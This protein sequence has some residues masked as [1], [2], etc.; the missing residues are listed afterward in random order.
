MKK[1][2]V[3]EGG[4]MRGMFTAGVL[5]V[6][7]EKGI[8]FNGAVGVS[9]GAVFGCNLKSHQIGRAIRYNKRFAGDPRYASFRSLLRTGDLYN[10]EFCYHT[11]PDELDPFDRE[12]YRADP[13]DFYVTVSDAVTG[14]PVY[15]LCNTGDDSDLK[16][17]QAS[18][19]M[20]VFAKPVAIDGG[21]YLDGGITDSIPVRFLMGKGYDRVVVVLTQ[22]AD[23]RKN[24]SGMHR[25][26]R[27]LLPKYPMVAECM[28]VRHEKYNETLDYI[29][30]MENEGKIMAI[31]PAA[32]LGIGK[33]ER[34]PEELERVYQ[35][36]RAECEKNL[37]KLKEYLNK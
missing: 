6:L 12:A 1:G 27:A 2:I 29:A 22:P 7:M 13:M 37:E 15:K 25:A 34:K 26:I 9:A 11:L 5:D 10:A 28:K 8:S 18:A 17:M 36:G 33:M 4:A 21:F 14:Q 24:A 23:Y 16:W 30:R 20:P 19:S 3:L 35:T 32:A 31:R